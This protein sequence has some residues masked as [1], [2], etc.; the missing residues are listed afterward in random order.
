MQQKNA[1]WWCTGQSIEVESVSSQTPKKSTGAIH[2]AQSFKD[3]FRVF[4]NF[5]E[6]TPYL[7]SFCPTKFDLFVTHSLSKL[8]NLLFFALFFASDVFWQYLEIIQII[9]TIKCLYFFGLEITQ[10]FQIQCRHGNNITGKVLCKVT[11]RR[12]RSHEQAEKEK[13][14]NILEEHLIKPGNTI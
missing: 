9:I 6:I 4:R 10:N 1:N 3:F 8:R 11:H 7:R 12:V 13:R 2:C 5:M 14:R